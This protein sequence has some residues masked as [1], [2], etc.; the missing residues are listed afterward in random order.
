MNTKKDI[1]A[2]SLEQLQEFFIANG[3]QKFRARQVMD[4]LWKSS[5]A[6]FEEM[7]NVS[8]KMREALQENFVIN[9]VK[10]DTKQVSNDRT[11]KN[12]FRLFDGNIVEGVLIPTENRMT[13]CVSSQ[14]GCS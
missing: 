12:A 2:L 9:A 8:K 3:E 5:A 6:T 7:N 14:V 1:R 13:A 4:W 10:I 11:I